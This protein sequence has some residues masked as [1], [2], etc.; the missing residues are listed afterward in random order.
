MALVNANDFDL[1][2]NRLYFSLLKIIL[3]KECYE[4]IRI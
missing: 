3:N 1:H 2:K 4:T